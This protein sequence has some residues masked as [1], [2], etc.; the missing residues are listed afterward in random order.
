MGSVSRAHVDIAGE[1]LNP[2]AGKP[3][4]QAG[5]SRAAAQGLN[6]AWPPHPGLAGPTAWGL[7]AV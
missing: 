6:T 5:S 1:A 7:A 2:R 4:P 3:R